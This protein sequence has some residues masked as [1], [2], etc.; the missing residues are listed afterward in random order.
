M[1]FYELPIGQQFEI[2]GEV[3]LKS[4]PLVAS[5]AQ[6][7]KQKFMV[8]SAMV[9]LLGQAMPAPQKEPQRQISADTVIAAFEQYYLRSVQVLAMLPA[10]QQQ[11]ARDELAQGR[12]VFLDSL[13]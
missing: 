5:H 13:N 6:T 1:K 11:A 7:G 4:S 10:V 9:G 2:D 8:R 12:K 3:Y